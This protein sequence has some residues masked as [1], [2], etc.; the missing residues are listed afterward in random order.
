MTIRLKLNIALAMLGAV[1]LSVAATGWIALSLSSE[2]TRA[3]VE[4]R[5]VPTADLKVVADMYA[6]NI[7]DAAHKI[8]SGAFGWVEGDQAMRMAAETI[9]EKW[10]G[11]LA[12]DLT[13][14]ERALADTAIA[15]M[16]AAEPRLARLFASVAAKD[17]A[18]LDAFVTD[19]LY[20]TI[21]P[22][23]TPISALVDLQI[24]VAQEEFA[25]AEATRHTSVFVMV[26][27]AGLS[28]IVLFAAFWTVSRGVAA[29]L[30]ALQGAMERLAAGDLST[31]IPGVGRRDEMGAMAGAVQVFKKSGLE[32]R[33]LEAE[34]AAQ[35]A[36]RDARAGT[37]DRLIST[38]DADVSLIL[39]TV[40]AAAS[41][42]EATAGSLSST[43][44][45]TAQSATTVGAASEQASANVDTV[46]AASEELSASLNEITGQVQASVAVA[47]RALAAASDSEQV[48]GDLVTAAGRIG[49][50]VELI[51]DIAGQTN[52]LAL[53]AT[54]EA[55]RAGEAGKGF[56]VVATEV[57]SLASQT[58]KA[59]Q[60]IS[61]QIGEMQGS[62][63][64]VATAIRSI[65]EIIRTITGTVAAISAAVEEQ[66]AATDEIA[67]NVSQAA[68]GTRQVSATIGSVTEAATH[69]GAGAAQVL[70]SSRELSR[71][72]ETLK[73]KVETFFAEIGAA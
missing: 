13:P 47:E 28:A 56:A 46:A 48:V 36:A 45:E 34:Q 67:R 43:A 57:K 12:G 60:E 38:F 73:A 21:D 35:R 54:I 68:V 10:S 65:A 18:A 15:A 41:E 71:Q 22:I 50:V 59:T 53:N 55:A 69:T 24:Q 72:S 52:L 44:E 26:A 70:S 17:Q 40:A 3:I 29:P 8:R 49:N 66:S 19:E 51:S 31:E 6:V 42:L 23:G 25:A 11:Y 27:A 58:A 64:Q 7:V 20:L 37:V 39:K 4:D 63:A 2:R 62:T 32:R 33:R 1:L 61:A 9:E 5:V 16:T 14:Q 30:A